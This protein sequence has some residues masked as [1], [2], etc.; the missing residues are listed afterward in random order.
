MQV[1]STGEKGSWGI[2][3]IGI[4]QEVN[5]KVEGIKVVWGNRRIGSSINV[6]ARQNR[7]CDTS[8]RDG[9]EFRTLGRV[10]RYR[11]ST[12][13]GCL[14]IIGTQEGDGRALAR[15]ELDVLPVGFQS[16][17]CH[18]V[19]QNARESRIRLEISRG[20]D[21]HTYRTVG[22]SQKSHNE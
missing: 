20:E 11:P 22:L 3:S 6:E 21:G 1:E 12:R 19:D 17:Y 9:D 8:V 2:P 10:A 5:K 4:E 14:G 18:P 7:W 16:R 13:V 15:G